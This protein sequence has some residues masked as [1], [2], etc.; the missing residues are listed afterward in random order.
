MVQ[1]PIYAH[2]L[3]VAE[4]PTRKPVQLTL[5]P[6]FETMAA[7]AQE[8]QL[9]GLR[10]LRFVLEIE[11]QG[12]S[13]WKLTGILGATVVQDCVVTLEPVT[14]RIDTPVRRIFSKSLSDS[15]TDE[16]FLDDETEELGDEIDPG[17]IMVEA[18]SIAIPDYPRADGSAFEGLQTT[19][20]GVTP[21]T[22]ETSKPFAVLSELRDK[23]NK[24]S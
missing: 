13:D 5:E 6:D 2:P 24:D 9:R 19:E 23:L 4:L 16:D 14:T 22:D 12:K 15:D 10:K 1:A 18:L 20:Q 3:R 8:L 11:A 7:I 21:L 17:L